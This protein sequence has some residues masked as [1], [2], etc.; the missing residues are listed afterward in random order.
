MQLSNLHWLPLW[1]LMLYKCGKEQ[2]TANHR[3]QLHILME[4]SSSLGLSVGPQ[5]ECTQLMWNFCIKT[6]LFSFEN[7]KLIYNWH[8]SL[9]KCIEY[10]FISCWTDIFVYCSVTAIIGLANISIMAHTYD[11]FF[12]GGKYQDTVS[13]SLMFVYNHSPVF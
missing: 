8:A 10:T 5:W 1:K 6:F 9:W 12:C 13:A 11:F 3:F 7:F 4:A 2:L